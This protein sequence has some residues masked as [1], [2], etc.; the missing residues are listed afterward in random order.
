MPE[1]KSVIFTDGANNEA[2][3]FTVEVVFP[4]IIAAL[5]LNPNK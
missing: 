5:L 4:V 3:I 2:L 1:K